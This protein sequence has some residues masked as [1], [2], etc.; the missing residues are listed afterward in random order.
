MYFLHIQI[1]LKDLNRYSD[2]VR[3]LIPGRGKRLFFVIQGPQLLLHFPIYAFMA[4]LL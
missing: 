1:E 3:A 4:F 2:G